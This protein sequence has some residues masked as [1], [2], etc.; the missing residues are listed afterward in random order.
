[1]MSSA[2]AVL[3]RNTAG[4]SAVI[5]TIM[6]A[7]GDWLAT[8]LIHST[9]LLLLALILTARGGRRAEYIWRICAF[10]GVFT[11]LAQ[12]VW[13][14]SP[15]AT[16]PL[17]TAA[18]APLSE[19][20]PP[21]PTAVVALWLIVGVARLARLASLHL[22]LRRLVAD[23][24]PMVDELLSAHRLLLPRVTPIRFTTSAR[25]QVPIALSNAEICFPERAMTE[26]S[27]TELGAVIA[28]EFAH[29]RR[30]DNQWLT[31]IAILEALL[32]VQPLNRLAS[33]KLRAIAEC[34]CDDWAVE[35]I[36]DPEPLATALVR[37]AGWIATARAPI[38]AIG[39]A[40][41][42]SVAL[43]RVRRILN[44]TRPQRRSDRLS[45]ALAVA[46]LPLAVLVAPGAAGRLTTI[47]A[48]DDGGPFTLTLNRGNVVSMTLDGGR[49]AASN[50]ERDGHH[51]RVRDRGQLI[52]DLTLDPSG[53]FRWKSRPPRT[54]S[55][56]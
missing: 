14:Y 7:L 9:A 35:C 27:A 21:L 40:S 18:P 51:L 38:A 1:M 8:Y 15:V 56:N 31:A 50:L 44:P 26:L 28:H 11:S 24:L 33:E 49:V 32:F 53:G 54:L 25:I 37:A 4:R 34:S 30:R 2:C 12:S 13:L 45:L 48:Y 52:L 29:L 46:A 16:L 39:I 6:S 5:E 47:S 20:L 55:K 36:R 19:G 23:R 42:Q 10:G 22:S 3:S 17:Y 43:I 41:T